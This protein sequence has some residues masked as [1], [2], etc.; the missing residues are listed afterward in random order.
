MEWLP[1]KHAIDSNPIPSPSPSP[2]P[3]PSPNPKQVNASARACSLRISMIWQT[4]PPGLKVLG[5][6]WG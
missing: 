6:R 5:Q 1:F 2:N 4:P 3:N